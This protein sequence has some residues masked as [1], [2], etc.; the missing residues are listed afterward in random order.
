MEERS[1]TAR[2]EEIALNKQENPTPVKAP[3]WA[4]R[5]PK[6]SQNPLAAPLLLSLYLSE[7]VV[8]LLV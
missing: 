4:G 5:R 6:Q 7:A 1:M 8:S 3:S 2:P